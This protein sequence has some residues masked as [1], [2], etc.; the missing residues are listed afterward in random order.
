VP[1]CKPDPAGQ[2]ETRETQKA[3]EDLAAQ[4]GRDQCGGQRLPETAE[5]SVV[6]LITA[7]IISRR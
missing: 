6:V 1:V 4:V 5:T 3:P 7:T 2:T